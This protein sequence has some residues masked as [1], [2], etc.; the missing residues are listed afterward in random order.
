MIMLLRDRR[1]VAVTEFGLVAVPLLLLVMGAME[2][3]Y[4]AY[5]RAVSLGALEALTRSIGVEGGNEATARAMLEAQ[6]RRVARQSV[7]TYQRGSVKKFGDL[8]AMEPM[9]QDHNGNGQVDAPV[10]SDADGAADKFDCWTD[11]DDNGLRNVV[12][13]GRDGIGGAD[14]VI[15]YGVTVTYNPLLPVRRLLNGTGPATVSVSTLVR[16]QPWQVQAPPVR[17]CRL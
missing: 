7:I 15:R 5:V 3:G 1:G 13:T 10:D 9:T 2:M 16:R 12:A 14:D 6:I 8:D 4:Q 17:R 11:T